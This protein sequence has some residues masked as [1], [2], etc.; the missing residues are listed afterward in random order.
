MPAMLTLQMENLFSFTC[1]IMNTN[2]QMRG[3]VMLRD[4]VYAGK[5]IETRRGCQACIKSSKCPAAELVRRI[6][7]GS[8]DMTDHCASTEEKVG[9]LPGDVLDKIA[10]ILVRES[11]LAGMNVT[12]EERNLI[13]SSRERIEAQ[14]L[15]APRERVEP[16]RTIASPSSEAPRRSAQKAAQS[17]PAPETTK[18]TSIS[19]A[20]ST[21]DLAAAL[22]AA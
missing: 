6:A 18:P 15:T 13:A 20:A 9:K 19:K 16:R 10:P 8:A 17:V 11:D 21:G 22:N 3:C 2:V 4:K 5:R 12:V 14:A 1:P 7:F